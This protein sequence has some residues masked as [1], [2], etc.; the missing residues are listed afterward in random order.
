MSIT[1]TPS[2]MATINS[3][4]AS[5]ASMMASAQNGGGTKTSEQFAPVLAI[6]L[7][8]RVEDREAVDFPVPPFPGVTPLTHDRLAEGDAPGRRPGTAGCWEQPRLAGDPW[9]MIFVLRST[10]M[11]MG[12]LRSKVFGDEQRVTERSR[13]GRTG[14]PDGVFWEGSYFFSVPTTFLA[15][16]VRSLAEMMFRPLSAS[17]LRAFSTFVPSRRTT[18]GT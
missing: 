9:V 15:A 18:S 16:S 10:R 2:V 11:L 14:P 4:P 12:A 1:G 17:I 3:I 8:H 7:G 13:M 5:A 6:A